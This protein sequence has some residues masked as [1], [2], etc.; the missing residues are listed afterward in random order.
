MKIR[1]SVI[2]KY[3]ITLETKYKY[4]IKPDKQKQDIT[5]KGTAMNKISAL[6]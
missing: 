4:N 1:R 6:Y 2:Q 5:K 3:E